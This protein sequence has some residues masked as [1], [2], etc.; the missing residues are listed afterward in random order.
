MTNK[1]GCELASIVDFDIR[2]KR[3]VTYILVYKS[4]KNAHVTEFISV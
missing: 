3:L 4:P 1:T 2:R